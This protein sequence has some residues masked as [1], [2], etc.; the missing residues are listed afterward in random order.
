[1]SDKPANKIVSSNRL[2]LKPSLNM[3]K[4]ISEGVPKSEQLA[5]RRRLLKKT[6]RSRMKAGRMR[7]PKPDYLKDK[8]PGD[9]R[10]QKMSKSARNARKLQIKQLLKQL[11]KPSSPAFCLPIYLNLT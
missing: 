8:K 7:Y 10:L 9:P 2:S 4:A 6:Q 5:A 3:F 11:P 1:M